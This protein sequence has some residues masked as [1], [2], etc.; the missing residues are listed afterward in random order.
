MLDAL[1][2]TRRLFARRPLSRTLA[3]LLAAA[4]DAATERR[5]TVRPAPGN[6]YRTGRCRTWRRPSRSAF[7]NA[8]QQHLG[9]PPADFRRRGEPREPGDTPT[10]PAPCNGSVLLAG[11]QALRDP[12]IEQYLCRLAASGQLHLIYPDR[13]RLPADGIRPVLTGVTADAAG[14]ACLADLRRRGIGCIWLSAAEAVARDEVPLYEACQQQARPAAE[15]TVLDYRPVVRPLLPLPSYPAAAPRARP[16]R[17]LSYR[18]HVPHQYELFKLGAEFTLLTN[19]GESSCRWWDLGQRPFPG[20]ARFAR[21]DEIDPAQFDLALLHFDEH[22][23]DVPDKDPAVGAD[24]GRSFRFLLS[25]LSIPRIAICHGTPQAPDAPTDPDRAERLRQALVDLLGDTPVV[26][27][28]HQAHAEWRFRNAR[29]IWQGFDPGEFPARPPAARQA[30]RILTL[31]HSAYALRPRYHGAELLAEVKNRISL[32]FEQL[33]V[34]EPNLLLNG[35]AYARAKFAHYVATLHRYAIYFNPT[36]HSPMPRTRG[37]AMLCGLATVSATSHDVDLF[38]RNGINGFHAGAAEELAEQ[39]SY[40]LDDPERAA[41]IARAGRATGIEL[42][43]IDRFLA[44][45]RRLIRDTLG[46]DAI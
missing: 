23:L 5:F 17:I 1:R 10:L 40:L 24:W 18:W 27:N 36:I 32:P 11:E 21:W 30:A 14:Q 38:I 29:V 31:P 3:A 16:L 19:L 22:I 13:F 46:A 37:E 35:N 15:G 39:I 34:P 2:K 26:V 7:I 42:F 8:L 6:G 33:S 9:I 41:R 44:D 4:R 28:S 25:A 20:N 43:G 45:W 12:R